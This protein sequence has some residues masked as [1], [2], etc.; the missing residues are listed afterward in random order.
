[1]DI[2]AQVVGNALLTSA[3]LAGLAF[4]ARSIIER[5]LS[6]NLERYKA[7]LE[8]QKAEQLE[9]I[10]VDFGL[11]A[12]E[13]ETRFARLHEKRV[14]VVQELYGKLVDIENC[15]EPELAFNM[16]INKPTRRETLA[17]INDSGRECID[18]FEKHRFYFDLDLCARI[19]SLQRKYESAWRELLIADQMSIPADSIHDDASREVKAVE[20]QHWHK[21][22]EIFEGAKQLRIDLETELRALLSGKGQLPMSTGHA[23]DRLGA[24]DVSSQ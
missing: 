22:S 16:S 8:A 21:A 4:L 7:D 5:W 20:Q 17:A 9:K 12:F 2:L 23:V 14:E 3:I 11:A 10:R 19:R 13:H 1:M 15:F 18:Y 24:Q 6:R